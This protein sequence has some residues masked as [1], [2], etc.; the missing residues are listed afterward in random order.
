[1]KMEAKVNEM[2]DAVE[3]VEGVC[4][5]K[6]TMDILGHILVNAQP[7]KVTLTGT[8]LEIAITARFMATVSVPG[9]V[10]V[11]GRKLSEALKKMSKD[12]TVCIE[13]KGSAVSVVSENMRFKIPVGVAADYPKVAM[14]SSG[15][16]FQVSESVLSQKFKRSLFAVAKEQSK[17]VL[18]GMLMSLKDGIFILCGTDGKC[19]SFTKM[20]AP[21]KD[22]TFRGIIPTG[23]VLEYIR[24][25]KSGSS[26]KVSIR[27]SDK[28]ICFEFE[29]LT[30]MSR[31]I[32]G[33]YP[34]CE[35]VVPIEY[36]ATAEL[37]RA[38]FLNA[39]N[40]MSLASGKDNRLTMLFEPEKLVLNSGDGEACTAAANVP[41]KYSGA[42]M[43]V[44]LN[45]G[46][47][48]DALKSN[49]AE[50]VVLSVIESEK[51][52]KL[53]LPTDESY[54]CLIMPLRVA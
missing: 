34:D 21:W 54:T 46:I 33:S 28:S 53:T 35:R 47:L 44:S 51:P 3:K 7:D 48:K 20:N 1:M 9:V 39:V 30:I 23:A 41:M 12:A 5:A 8:N 31:L 36:K 11:P 38:E 6:G 10:A 19:L 24:S 25:A 43:Q 14:D 18:S 2:L 16:Q 40:A 49:D 32:E 45:A 4:E 17:P 42:G 26:S 27:F 50:R 52:L 29:N 22:I 15:G 13:L 37:S